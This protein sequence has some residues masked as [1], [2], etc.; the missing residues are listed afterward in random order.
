MAKNAA[1]LF[2]QSPQNKLD[3]IRTLQQQGQ[4]VVMVGDGLNDAGALQQADVGM[5]ISENT[6]NFSPACDV[7]VEAKRFGQLVDFVA[8]SK[9]TVKV[10]KAAFVL[11]FLYNFVGIAF[12]V[13][14]FLSPIVAAILMPL[15]S[16]T[17]VVFG[18]LGSRWAG[19]EIQTQSKNSN[20]KPEVEK[21]KI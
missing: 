16:V 11:S 2:E 21:Q 19:K 5:A 13:Q 6:N 8:Y 4:R 1:L 15:S 14:G 10:V 12:A 18:V 9:S 7:I 20:S 3:Y 17:V